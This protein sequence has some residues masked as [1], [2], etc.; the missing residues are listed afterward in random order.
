MISIRES[1]LLFRV[2]GRYGPAYLA[3]DTSE[4]FYLAAFAVRIGPEGWFR[5]NPKGWVIRRDPGGRSREGEPEHYHCHKGS[6]DSG[7]EIVITVTGEGSHKTESGDRIPRRLG[8]YLSK[9]L[10][11]PIKRTGRDYTVRLLTNPLS[12][13]ARTDAISVL[14]TV[15]NAP[16]EHTWTVGAPVSEDVLL[17]TWLRYWR[18][19]EPDA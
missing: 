4:P 5:D 18:L 3:I 19:N 2:E 12:G 17:E 16:T 15:M 10:G 7:E 11:L 1:V 14:N 8:D 13:P 6:K 9:E